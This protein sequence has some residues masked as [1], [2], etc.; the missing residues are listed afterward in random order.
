MC[1]Y[2]YDADPHRKYMDWLSFCRAAKLPLTLGRERTAEGMS[3]RHIATVT[4]T[5]EAVIVERHDEGIVQDNS[6]DI[7]D[8]RTVRY[9]PVQDQRFIGQVVIKPESMQ[10]T[11]YDR[12]EFKRLTGRYPNES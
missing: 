9:A 4:Y 11:T 6:N 10:F 1:I 8:R 7:N 2:D 3:D 12:E 5:D